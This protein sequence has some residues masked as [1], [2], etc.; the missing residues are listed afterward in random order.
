M[1][2]LIS[3]IYAKR[4]DAIVVV[5]GTT[6]QRSAAENGVCDTQ[7]RSSVDNS[8]CESYML[9]T[10]RF[11]RPEEWVIMI[12]SKFLRERRTPDFKKRQKLSFETSWKIK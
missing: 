7:H 3:V 2:T 10:G 5:R 12:S 1:R 4:K 6:Q 11:N 9:L 8:V